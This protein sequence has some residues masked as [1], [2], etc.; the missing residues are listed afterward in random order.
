MPKIRVFTSFDFDHD[1]DLRTLLVGQ[2]KLADSPFDLADWSL[3]EPL[4]GDWKAKIRT[5]IKSVDQVVVMCGLHT[6]TATGVSAELSIA[7]E[8]GKPY[9]LL[10]G[11]AKGGN[12]R[13]T[14]AK[15]TDKLYDW[16]WANLKKLIGGA[17]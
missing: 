5:R 3:K 10:A 8:E 14:A 17:R 12:T 6:H 2:S 16:T 1:Q 13:P 7:Q 15:Q 11:R 4:T 9:F